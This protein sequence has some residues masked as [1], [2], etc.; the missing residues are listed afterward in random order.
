MHEQDK[1]TNQQSLSNMPGK[2]AEIIAMMSAKGGVGK[3][4]LSVN[5]A[6]TCAG[7]GRKVLLIDC[8]I[9]TYGATAFFRLGNYLNPSLFDEDFLTF[10]KML[11]S[12]G[13]SDAEI[14]TSIILSFAYDGNSEAELA[15]IPVFF[16]DTLRYFQGIDISQERF[17]EKISTGFGKVLNRFRTRYDLIIL[18]LAAGTSLFNDMLIK[19]ADKV[20]FVME[21]NSLS[22]LSVK[23]EVSK[24][25][26]EIGLSQIIFLYNKTTDNSEKEGESFFHEVD[27]IPFS[28]DFASYYCKGAFIEWGDSSNCNCLVR[29]ISSICSEHV[30]T[31]EAFSK[32]MNIVWKKT[33]YLK[34]TE[35]E[36]KKEKNQLEKETVSTLGITVFGGA[37]SVVLAYYATVA[38]KD[39]YK[40]VAIIFAVLFGTAVISGLVMTI[41]EAILLIRSI[42]KNRKLKNL[43]EHGYQLK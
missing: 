11:A 3:T 38:E 20:C 21:Q 22:Y 40:L 6:N 10:E 28:S 36:Y 42:R 9:H 34:K 26:R 24:L 37:V 29:V 16:E 35:N 43:K 39:F 1:D 12:A 31:K 15:V 25:G 2:N 33:G 13:E 41:S 18:D 23:S 27:G 7:V 5:I 8:D 19:N 32:A 4:S 30:F 17:V 14:D